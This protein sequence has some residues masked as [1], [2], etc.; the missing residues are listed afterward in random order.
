[1]RDSSYYLS[2]QKPKQKFSQGGEKKVMKKSLPVLVSAA[3]AFGSFASL[4][5]AAEP[6]TLEKFNALK[7]KGIFAGVNP[8]GDAGLD[9]KMNR[10]QFARVAAL[11]LGLEGIGNPDTLKVTEKP[12]S[13]VDLGK[14]YTEE[15]AAVK[16][17]KIMQGNTD[18][19]FDP[20]D[21]ITV[22][23]LAVV[24]AGLLKLT[25]VADAKVTG[26]ADWAGPYLKALQD[27][28]VAFPTN[29]TEAATRS[30]LV[31]LSYTANEKLNPTSVGI[32]EAK[33]SG[34]SKITV[35]LSGPVDTTKAKLE[36][37][38]NNSAATVDKTEWSADGRT[39]TLTLSSK[40]IAATYSVTLSGIENL[41]STKA[42]A[43]FEGAVEKIASIE[44]VTAS[45]T[46]PDADGVK[47][48]FKALNQYG[49]VSPLNA[50]N[51]TISTGGVVYNAVSGE[52]AITLN[53]LALNKGDKV[54]VTIIHPDSNAQAN[55]I[56]TVGEAPIVSKIELGDLKDG[57]NKVI[58]SLQPGKT[59][60]I[61]Y[62]AYDQYGVEVTDD[63]LLNGARGVTTVI[64]DN[65]LVKGTDPT[66]NNGNA[67]VPNIIGTTADDL[68]I[69]ATSSS[70]AKDVTL[71]FFANGTGQ[72]VQ[73]VVKITTPSIPAT[74]EFGDFTSTL[75][76]GDTNVYVPLVV[77]DTTGKALT[78]QEIADNASKF[79]VY[80]T[81]GVVTLAPS[82]IQ[83]SGTNKGKILI[84]SVDRKGNGS[85]VI[86]M[87]NNPAVKATLNLSTVDVRKA[88]RIAVS[89]KA[90]DKLLV[91][92]ATAATSD[93]KLKTFDQYGGDSKVSTLNDAYVKLKVETVS[94]DG[95]AATLNINNVVAA[96]SLATGDN[97]N[98]TLSAL[99][100]KALTWTAVPNK[101]GTLRLTATL[102]DAKG[103]GVSVNDVEL[104]SATSTVTVYDGKSATLTYD[105]VLD[106]ATDSTIYAAPKSG[107]AALDT[108]AEIGATLLSKAVKVSAKEGSA[109]V[110]LPTGIVQSVSSSNPSVATVDTV[111]GK[112]VGLAS[113]TAD[114]SVL[115]T[116]PTGQSSAAVKVT[117]KEDRPSAQSVAVTNGSKGAVIGDFAAPVAAATFTGDITVT[118]QYGTAY[119][120]TN[121]TVAP[122]S[123]LL[124]MK[125]FIS[126]VKHAAGSSADS[127]SINADSGVITFTDAGT[128]GTSDITSFTINIIAPNGK[129]ASTEVIF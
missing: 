3:L 88:E 101:A 7:A 62:K 22:Q 15:V 81:G 46:L 86:Q 33:A 9:Q 129:T 25:P 21:D 61:E 17:A 38:R 47:V 113:G 53:L 71:S 52:Q 97:A 63:V 87:T 16:A 80:A 83:T 107:D 108:P 85:I 92:A 105:V 106:G 50:S 12:F 109:V 102:Y 40:I 114:L 37:K 117:V 72:S 77:K 93:V 36:V 78:A 8:A 79:T 54:P 95:T 20:T 68:A 128:I 24:A 120:Q 51:F 124:G 2:K 103:D 100:D 125:F 89:T 74:V 34:V 98:V 65:N 110:A 42:S 82:A 14:W 94:G 126:N 13:D 56:F 6:T 96:T 112:V 48:S 104:G 28:G 90:A 91:T 70:S 84:T 32:A 39:A 43:T 29:Y 127:V 5:N 18:G 122:Y 118:D 11:I 119:K 73:K 55:K 121:F 75:A 58:E 57:D 45:E 116:T 123:T 26:A 59:A 76:T 64:P 19:T 30:Q 10:A 35:S 99:F 44:F 41:D 60:Y 66:V 115:F 49:E 27:A 67:F 111:T 31:D 4:A 1:M 69:S 23:E